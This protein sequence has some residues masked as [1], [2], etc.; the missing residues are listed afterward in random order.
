[1]RLLLVDSKECAPLCGIRECTDGPT[2]TGEGVLQSSLAGDD[3][4][5]EV[6]DEK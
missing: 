6:F 4:R 2:A 1:M 3:W 5:E